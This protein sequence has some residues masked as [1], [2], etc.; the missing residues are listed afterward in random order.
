M[1][2]PWS[3][4]D[5]R[6]SAFLDDEL[7]DDEALEVVRHLAACADC[8]REFEELREAREALRRLETPPAVP[9][10]TTGRDRGARTGRWLAV[11]AAGVLGAAAVGALADDADPSRTPLHLVVD[12]V[13]LPGDAQPME[14]TLIG[15]NR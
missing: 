1:T 10:A 13:L 8:W 5:E 3:H 7:G 4:E 14:A 11:V 2:A 6:L 9:L 15:E 12:P